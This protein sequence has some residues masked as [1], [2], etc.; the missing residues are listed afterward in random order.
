[1]SDTSTLSL[2][3]VGI[4]PNAPLTLD[5]A[6]DRMVFVAEGSLT[7]TDD[8]H[9][10]RN[11]RHTGIHAIGGSVLTAEAEGT[12]LWIWTISAG[13]APAIEGGRELMS[14]PLPLIEGFDGGQVVMRLDR[15]DFPP[16]AAAHTH[17]HPGPG[18]RVV[19]NGKIGIQQGEADIIWMEPGEPWFE[20]GPKPVFAPTTETEPTAFIRCL[21]LPMEWRGRN[22]IRYIDPADNEKPKLQKYYRFCDAVVELP[23]PLSQ[24]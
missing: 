3:E 18:L 4:E 15:V 14:R 9:I 2:V 12:R 5:G 22:T 16:G 11:E 24:D 8:T 10:R 13:E 17:V 1:M 19:L 6:E 20:L 23:G 21:V 7:T